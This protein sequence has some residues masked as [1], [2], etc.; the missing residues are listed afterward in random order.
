MWGDLGSGVP[1]SIEPSEP[2]VF[3]S[4]SNSHT[5]FYLFDS[6]AWDDELFDVVEMMG[7]KFHVEKPGNFLSGRCGFSDQVFIADDEVRIFRITGEEID[8]SPVP[9]DGQVKRFEQSGIAGGV[10]DGRHCHMKRI[11]QDDDEM[12]IS[13]MRQEQVNGDIGGGDFPTPD[14]VALVT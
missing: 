11:T 12:R 1:E 6:I 13:E 2:P 8:D 10:F 3:E 5:G 14:M 9:E 4:F 7:L